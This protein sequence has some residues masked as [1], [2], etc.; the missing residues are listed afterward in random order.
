MTQYA[1]ETVLKVFI[2]IHT[3]SSL[4]WTRNWYDHLTYG[5]TVTRTIRQ[6]EL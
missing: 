2:Q 6:S 1:L 4:T 5:M 3:L